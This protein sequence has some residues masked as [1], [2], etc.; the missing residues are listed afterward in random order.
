M[1]THTLV[2][3]V[4]LLVSLFSGC[5]KHP[6]V[7]DLGVVK[8]SDGIP[9]YQDLGGSRA[10]VITPT[11]LKSNIVSL[12][13]IIQE[14]NSAGV[15]RMV[16]TTRVDVPAGKPRQ[17]SIGDNFDIRLIPEVER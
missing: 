5:S 6:K 9:T 7:T 11:M 17:I 2:A 16:A 4:A 8:I 3:I 10:C 15:I 12:A 14:T 13:I 1:N